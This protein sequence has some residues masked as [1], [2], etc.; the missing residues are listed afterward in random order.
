M[1]SE[2]Q[3]EVSDY[4]ADCGATLYQ[5]GDSFQW[6]VDYCPYSE[7]GHRVENEIEIEAS[8]E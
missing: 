7:N 5:M 8:Y 3:W 2:S 1:K 6:S 4:C